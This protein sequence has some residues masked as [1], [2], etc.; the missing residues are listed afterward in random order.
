MR[1]GYPCINTSL[2]CTANSTFRLINYS[3][4]KLF[5]TVEKNLDCLM[6]ILRWNKRHGL[7]FFRIGSQLIPFASHPICKAN[8]QNKFKKHFKMIGDYV[9]KNKIRLSMHPD[10]FVLIN[11]LKQSVLSSS[12]R[13]LEY[14]CQVLDLMG[15]PR[16]AKIQIH[17]GGIYQEK[18]EAI[19]RFIA[20]YQRLDVKVKKR[21]SIENDHRL[22]SL[23]DCL[24]IN[25]FIKIPV[26]FDVFH[27]ECL[28]N[29]ES[30]R[31]ALLAV[32]KTWKKK[33]GLP[34]LDYSNQA[35]NA[36][37]GSHSKHINI[38]K[39]RVFLQQVKG[40][41]FDLMLEI[42]DKEKSAL[43]ARKMQGDII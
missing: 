21:L 31:E 23:N 2:N 18:I 9:L 39:F 42:K 20:N 7:L 27:H 38:E 26:I 1:I 25:K 33:D 8:W 34:I 3:E 6:R 19:K 22:F 17:V 43:I 35:L 37:I 4:K 12:L 10:Q 40:F 36:P 13:E 15:L 24:Y 32:K 29:G 11:S 5:D 30:L 41:N 28:N 14:H 16:E